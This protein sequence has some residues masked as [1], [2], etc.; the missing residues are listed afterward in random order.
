MKWGQG[1]FH[2]GGGRRKLRADFTCI[3]RQAYCLSKGFKTAHSDVEL[4]GIS[5]LRHRPVHDYGGTNWSMVA[6]IILDDL[7]T[8]LE[9]VDVI[10]ATLTSN[11]SQA[12]GRVPQD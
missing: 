4:P 12:D 3:T 10:L 5:G 2:A 11:S 7:P 1:Q 8:F 9:Q 6:S